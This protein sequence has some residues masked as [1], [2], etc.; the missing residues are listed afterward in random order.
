MKIFAAALAGVLVITGS[1]YAVDFSIS[2]EVK[3]GVYFEQRELEGEVTSFTV[4][5]N[6]DSDTG[7]NEGRLRLAMNLTHE[8]FGMRMRFHQVDFKTDFNQVDKFMIDYIYAYGNLFNEQLKI[9][10]GLLGESPWGTGGPR[11]F[12]ELETNN[13]N[14]HLLGI[15]TEWM[16]SFLPGLNL[17]FVLN[18]YDNRIPVTMTDN[19]KEQE[20][21]DVLLDSVLG[22]GY[23]H[24]YFAFRFSY[25]LDSMADMGFNDQEGSRFV[26]RVEERIL[27]K[28]V[29][30]L[31]IWA[32]GYCFGINSAGQEMNNRKFE[33]WF[34]IQYDTAD[35]T[36]NCNIMYLDTL[37]NYAKYLRVEPDFTYKFFNNLLSAGLNAGI[38]I[39]FDRGK[40][41]EN[42]PYNYWFIGPNVQLNIHANFY[43]SLYYQ[44][45]AGSFQSTKAGRQI[46]L[47]QNTHWVNLRLCY[48]F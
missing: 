33:N 2:G 9:S 22:I 18:R 8:N 14:T 45:N 4:V 26:Y 15:R 23:E 3:T 30:G 16:P 12:Q 34:F 40:Y 28:L 7:P 46:F 42:S 10:A 11:L 13:V 43:A 1:V 29:P 6:N 20:I 37:I 31:Q 21:Y 25:R 39:G 5:H 35:F 24:E 44:Y 27:R 32:N 48:T 41:F 36:V 19:A 38:E 17:G 47:D